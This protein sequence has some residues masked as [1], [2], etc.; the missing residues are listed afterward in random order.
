[1]M[2]ATAAAA[3]TRPPATKGARRRFAGGS[4][5]S[6]PT[7]GGALSSRIGVTAAMAFAR[8]VLHLGGHHHSAERS[9]DLSVPWPVIHVSDG[10]RRIGVTD[11][12]DCGFQ[13]ADLGRS[14]PSGR[15]VGLTVGAGGKATVR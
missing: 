15:M 6:C 9:G 13:A 7:S 12:G 2:P 14:W 11:A 8:P 1:M 5:A 3:S 10:R 4:G